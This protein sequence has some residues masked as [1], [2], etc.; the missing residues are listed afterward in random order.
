MAEFLTNGLLGLLLGWPLLVGDP[1]YSLVTFKPVRAYNLKVSLAGPEEVK[2]GLD[3]YPL[4]TTL[5]GKVG[6]NSPL[7]DGDGDLVLAD[8]YFDENRLLIAGALERFLRETVAVLNE[9]KEWG[10]KIEGH[11]DSRGTSAYNLARADYHLSSLEGFLRYLEIPSWR[12]QRVNFGQTP[13]TCRS[14]S[15]QCRENNLRAEKIFSL[16]AIDRFQRGCL[17][18]L[19]LVAGKDG[20]RAA[21][22]LKRSPY[23]QR[24]QV[25]SPLLTVF[26]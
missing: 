5:S 6:W 16:L 8:L 13:F 21:G 9:E 3:I 26:R 22:Y 18:R 2:D 20:D 12:I 7:Q 24:I 11:C 19:R 1:G 14:G 17:A 23:L 4:G 10:L 25:A 15:E